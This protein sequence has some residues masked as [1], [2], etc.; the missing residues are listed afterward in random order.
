MVIN[1]TRQGGFTNIAKSTRVDTETLPSTKAK[2]IKEELSKL[3][4]NTNQLC[5]GDACDRFTYKISYDDLQGHRQIIKNES[6]VAPL[7]EI[8][9]TT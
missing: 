6:S 2:A 4:S 3:V 5:S 8:I 1:I 7:L 9:A